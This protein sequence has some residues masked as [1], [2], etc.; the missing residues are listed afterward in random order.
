MATQ[1]ALKTFWLDAPDGRL[2]ARE[3]AKAWA[4]REV[5]R[6]EGNG[7]HGL[8][9]WVASKVK[10]TARGKPNGAHPGRS[11]MEQFFCKVDEDS[12]WFPGKH[13]GVRRG[14]KRVA[15]GRPSPPDR[16]RPTIAVRPSRTDRRCRP[17]VSAP[18]APPDHRRWP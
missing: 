15:A 6:E 18:P 5:W 13:N 12:D 3:Q 2:C 4:L 1:D 10:K 16:R 17:T 8:Y 11:A 7:D 14:P 9:A